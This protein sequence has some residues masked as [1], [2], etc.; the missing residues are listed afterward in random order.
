M[1]IQHPSLLPWKGSVC[2][3][4]TWLAGISITQGVIV[5]LCHVAGNSKG[6]ELC[7]SS[8]KVPAAMSQAPLLILPNVPTALSSSTPGLLSDAEIQAAEH[9]KASDMSFMFILLL[10]ANISKT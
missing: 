8:G 6:R 7:K 4:L 9:E 2:E 1:K 3:A 5:F 10:L